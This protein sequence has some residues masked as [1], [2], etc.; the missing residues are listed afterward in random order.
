MTGPN[1][2]S[3]LEFHFILIVATLLLLNRSFL[4]LS[5][6]SVWTSLFALIVLLNLHCPWS[7]YWM[8]P[9]SQVV[10]RLLQYLNLNVFIFRA[11]KWTEKMCRIYCWNKIWIS[12]FSCCFFYLLKDAIDFI[13]LSFPSS[14][15]TFW[16]LIME[17]FP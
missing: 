11:S 10:I 15:F 3:L 13:R 2:K 5:F 17:H 16:I 7:W 4:I 6:V 9:L 1:N 8:L 14:T 12:K